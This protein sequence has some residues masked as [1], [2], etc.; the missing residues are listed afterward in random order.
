M[1]HFWL[2][3]S[4]CQGWQ[5]GANIASVHNLCFPASE[6]YSRKCVRINSLLL[7]DLSLFYSNVL[8]IPSQPRF[9]TRPV[10]KRF[11][12]LKA[13]S[14]SIPDYWTFHWKRLE[15]NEIVH[16]VKC[17]ILIWDKSFIFWPL[18]VERM[19]TANF[20]E[21]AF[22]ARPAQQST[23]GQYKLDLVWYIDT[24]LDKSEVVLS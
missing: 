11:Q 17:Q 6:E 13:D 14:M 23:W 24:C 3:F 7:L 22:A 9:K 5:K 16:L 15:K 19:S 12:L 21:L 18:Q 2:P 20:W 1:R 8:A 4:R 10:F